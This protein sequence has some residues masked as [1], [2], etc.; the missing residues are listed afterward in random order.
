MAVLDAVGALQ[1]AASSREL[2]QASLHGIARVVQ[3]AGYGFYVL[4]PSDL[5][6][7]DV[8]ATVPDEFLQRYE[9]EGRRD[10]PVLVQALA[11]GRPA[12]SS[13]LPPGRCWT[14]SA[15]FGVLADAGYHHSLEA[16][17]LVDGEVRATLNMARPS[18]AP[19]FSTDDLDAM[20]VV[21][22]HV[23]AA[24]T[25]ARRYDQTSERTVLLADALDAASQAVVIT[26][27]EG[28]LIFRNRMAHRQIPGSS[29]TYLERAHPVLHDALAQL[30]S[31][32]SRIVT[33][34]EGHLDTEDATA[35]GGLRP[36]L[37]GGP[38]T[39]DQRALPG[40]RLDR[41][42]GRDPRRPLV[43]GAVTVKA[44][45]LASRHDAVVSFV[46][47]RA[48]DTGGLPDAAV[49]LSPREREI[50]DLVSQG[51]TTRRIA[52][53]S[54]VS[55][56]TVKQHLKRIFAKLQV[57]SRAELVQTVWRSASASV[58][59][60]GADDQ[61]TVGDGRT[62]DHWA[63]DDMSAADGTRAAGPAPRQPADG[64]I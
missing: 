43:T 39:R 33:A 29:D 51:L 50:A 49:P 41:A 18:A 63:A 37:D 25:R 38:A 48:S 55:E 7:V 12:D 46:S 1:G 34:V 53:L 26:T 2:Q 60:T 64:G 58:D 24:L 47:Y 11:S 32:R 4:R 40:H 54:F 31:G 56:N 23:G 8:M 19:P 59:A 13:R 42:V 62:A 30:R 36:S 27:A 10:D 20:D 6:P 35:V 44:V 57:S 9:D 45:R 28:E 52:E 3:A 5:T 21:A 61:L 16:P 22:E 14:H 15:V 17:V